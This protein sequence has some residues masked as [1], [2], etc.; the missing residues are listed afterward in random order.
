M[1]KYQ[2]TIHTKWGSIVIGILQW[3]FL[4]ESFMNI[5]W[6]WG[7]TMTNT[8]T[9]EGLAR[10]IIWIRGN[11]TKRWGSLA[12]N[13]HLSSLKMNI[14][15]FL[16]NLV[17]KF[18]WACI[19]LFNSYFMLFHTISRSSTTPRN[20]GSVKMSHQSLGPVFH[21]P[22]GNPGPIFGSSPGDDST[23]WASATLW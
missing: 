19:Q 11:G 20:H 23:S 15:M 3:L 10:K 2:I 21:I 14:F 18:T 1:Q 16:Q 12:S 8:D 7:T 22:T 6:E 5:A 13:G 9:S 17:P 4:R